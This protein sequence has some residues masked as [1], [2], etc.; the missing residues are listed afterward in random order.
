MM[1]KQDA[2][3]APTRFIDSGSPDVI[4]F[5]REH[6][7]GGSDRDRAIRLYYAVRDGVRYDMTTFGLDPAQFVASNCLKAPSA[8]CVPKAIVLAA[9]ARAAGIPA[10]IGFANVRNHLTSPRISA[11]MDTDLFLW[12]AYTSLL[13]DGKWVKATPAFD[14]ALC[15]RH[16]VKPLDFDGSEDSILHP[17][18]EAGR[19]HMEYVDF[20]GEYDDL[21][22][23]TFAAE[24]RAHYPVMLETLERERAARQ[25][26]NQQSA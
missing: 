23:E 25:Q 7:G 17:F 12:H 15:T 16:K 21:P 19:K 5:A 18:D 20:L 13:I 2:T 14:I 4:A 3:L 9:A 6:A 24:M 22:F 26:D 11:M 8:F 1:D 10:R